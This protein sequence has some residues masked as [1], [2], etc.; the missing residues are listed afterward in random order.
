MW[1]RSFSATFA[2]SGE[3]GDPSVLV[4]YGT[5]IEAV[6]SGGGTAITFPVADAGAGILA[7]AVDLTIDSFGP[8]QPPVYVASGQAYTLKVKANVHEDG[9]TGPSVEGLS[10][11]FASTTGAT[12]SPATVATDTNGVATSNVIV[13]YGTPLTA[14]ISGGGTVVTL[15]SGDA[16]LAVGPVITLDASLDVPPD[17]GVGDSPVACTVTAT[18]QVGDAA[19]VGLPVTFGVTAIQ[20][21][22]GS[23]AIAGPA[24]PILTAD[25]GSASYTF[26][27]PPA[28]LHFTAV[29]SG[30]G[31]VAT[32]NYPPADD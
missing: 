6:V 14:I 1:S 13:P 24:S 32:T 26:L 18:A 9:G 17:A 31:A 29:V 23:V 25:G 15:P 5:Q 22:T 12:F 4:P 3:S 27:V 8:V 19:I 30:G 2:S 20:A 16:R 7:P 11:S 10:I 28:V 21:A